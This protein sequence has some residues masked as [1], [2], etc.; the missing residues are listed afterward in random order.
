MY[1]GGPGFKS[2]SLKQL[3]C[4]WLCGLYHYLEKIHPPQVGLWPHHFQVVIISSFQAVLS[5]LRTVSLSKPVISR[6]LHII[7]WKYFLGCDKILWVTRCLYRHSYKAQSCVH[8]AA[9]TTHWSLLFIYLSVYIFIF[10]CMHKKVFRR[11]ACR[12]ITAWE[13]LDVFTEFYTDGIS[14]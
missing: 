14:V 12:H 3:S 7:F 13:P 5:E 10:L 2:W 6:T 11:C 1:L 4:W 8:S 9:I